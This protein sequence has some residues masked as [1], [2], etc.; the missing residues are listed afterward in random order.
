MSLKNNFIKF[1]FHRNIV[2][3]S[4]R[5]DLSFEINKSLF[6]PYIINY[7]PKTF[8]MTFIRGK[9]SN[10]AFCWLLGSIAC[11]NGL[12]CNMRQMLMKLTSLP[13]TEHPFVVNNQLILFNLIVLFDQLSLWMLFSL[14][15][16]TL[17][18]R[19]RLAIVF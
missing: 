1:F 14:S 9:T 16:K 2:M 11:K 8:K 12:F 19:H 17:R 15:I 10:E 4:Q 13:N 3:I 5:F 6:W 18:N 7:F